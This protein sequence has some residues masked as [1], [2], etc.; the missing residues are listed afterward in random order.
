MYIYMRGWVLHA[1]THRS[2]VRAENGFMGSA[3]R[4]NLKQTDVRTDGD[5]INVAIKGSVQQRHGEEA[6]GVL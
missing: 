5:D 2:A 6:G 1:C 4:R 3:Y